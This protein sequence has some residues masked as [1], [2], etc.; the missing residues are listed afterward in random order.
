MAFINTKVS[1]IA[2]KE[3]PFEHLRKGVHSFFIQ[4]SMLGKTIPLTE[5]K[6]L[7]QARFSGFIFDL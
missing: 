1:R 6:N 7:F 2:N 5:Y 3:N 4:Q